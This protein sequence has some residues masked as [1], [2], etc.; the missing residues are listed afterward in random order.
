MKHQIK[1]IKHETFVYGHQK[2][3]MS[4]HTTAFDIAF[5][6]SKIS[7]CKSI[8]VN[9]MAMLFMVWFP[10]EPDCNAILLILL[11]SVSSQPIYPLGTVPLLVYQDYQTHLIS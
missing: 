2:Y 6:P 11:V 8:T 3:V 7:Y 5:N 9:L 10:V 4:L 1:H